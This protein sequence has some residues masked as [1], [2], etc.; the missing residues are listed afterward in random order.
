MNVF[1]MTY[2]AAVSPNEAESVLAKMPV[3]LNVNTLAFS[4]MPGSSR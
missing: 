1:V 3:Y 4:F 2:E